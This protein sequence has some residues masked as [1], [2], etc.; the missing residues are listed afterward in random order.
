MKTTNGRQRTAGGG[1][2]A[3]RAFSLIELL[4]VIG[5]IIALAGLTFPVVNAVKRAQAIKRGQA[6]LAAVEMAI[7]AYKEKLGYFPPDNAP[8]WYTNQLYYE[9]LGCKFNG[10]AF[11]VLDGSALIPSSQVNNAFPTVQGIMNSAKSGG[12]EVAPATKFFP[13]LK[14]NQ[15]LT[16]DVQGKNGTV[17]GVNLLGVGMSGGYTLSGTAGG[18]LTPFGYCSS[19]P[20]HNSKTFDVWVD[21]LVSGKTNRLCNWSERPILVYYTTPAQAYPGP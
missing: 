9:L 17:K 19:N 15:F 14:P 8:N 13:N 1:R 3:A 20:R 4:V 18:E 6:E 5:V 21:I 16:L 10:A 11:Q 2:Q 12:D 7:Q